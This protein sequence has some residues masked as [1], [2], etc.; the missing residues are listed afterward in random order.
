LAVALL[1]GAICVARACATPGVTIDD[2]RERIEMSARERGANTVEL[3]QQW[4]ANAAINPMCRTP[5]SLDGSGEPPRPA[6]FAT[7][8]SPVVL[9]LYGLSRQQPGEACVHSEHDACV[10]WNTITRVGF[11]RAR[12]LFAKRAEDISGLPSWIAIPEAGRLGAGRGDVVGSGL[13]LDRPMLVFAY[14]TDVLR[15]PGM[16][17]A[18]ALCELDDDV[19]EAAVLS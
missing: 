4:Y 10:E 11:R 15:R 16:L 19:M 17:N 9:V 13:R 8:R 7:L 3:A 12:L 2:E 6:Q 18:V 14:Y 1:S 5:L